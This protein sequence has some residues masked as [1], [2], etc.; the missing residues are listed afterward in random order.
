[1]ELGDAQMLKGRE[2][3]LAQLRLERAIER[4]R[5]K[6]VRQHWSY[7]LNR[8][9]ALKQALDLIK[10]APEPNSHDGLMRHSRRK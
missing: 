1:M 4:E 7:D 9:I 5:L 2:R 10:G 3:A 8:H 6:G